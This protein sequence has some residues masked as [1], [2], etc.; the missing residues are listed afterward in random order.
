MDQGR[1][2]R[3]KRPRI[4]LRNPVVGNVD[5]YKCMAWPKSLEFVKTLEDR[6]FLS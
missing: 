2:L 4:K 6:A 1:N 5:K 3:W